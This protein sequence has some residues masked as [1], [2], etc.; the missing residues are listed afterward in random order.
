MYEDL[1]APYEDVKQDA[2]RLKLQLIKY[3]QK[4]FGLDVGKLHEEAQQAKSRQELAEDRVDVLE[5]DLFDIRNKIMG[6]INEAERKHLG[7]KQKKGDKKYEAGEWK[8]GEDVD[9][10]CAVFTNFLTSPANF[11]KFY[12]E[13]NGSVKSKDSEDGSPKKKAKK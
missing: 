11:Q 3:E 7:R 4:Y 13:S 10:L 5:R 9:K 1:L 8:A 12:S 6:I 2:R